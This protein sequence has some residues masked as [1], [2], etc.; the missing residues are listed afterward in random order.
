MA[1]PNLKLPNTPP[2]ATDI[3]VA[4]NE[5]V[6]TIDALVPLVVQAM[7][8]TAPPSTL[9][10]DAGKRWLVPVGATGAWAGQA[11]KVAL[12]TGADTWRFIE[13]PLWHYARDLDSAADYRQTAPGTWT[14]V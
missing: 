2:G 3:S 13:A 12:C 6:Q 9:A 10:G 11:G 5:A 1:T 7:D 4:Y 8:L 14:A